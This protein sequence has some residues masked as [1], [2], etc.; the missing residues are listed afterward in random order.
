VDGKSLDVAVK[1]EELKQE[2]NAPTQM[3][4]IFVGLS[5]VF[6]RVAWKQSGTAMEL[7][8]EQDLEQS[9][10]KLVYRSVLELT[11]LRFS[12]SGAF[13]KGDDNVCRSLFKQSFH[14][15]RP[16]RGMGCAG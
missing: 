13:C 4:S 14:S 5:P 7:N 8:G 6:S 2:D 1:H 11:L 9:M 12:D 15:R 10:E 3:S 16:C